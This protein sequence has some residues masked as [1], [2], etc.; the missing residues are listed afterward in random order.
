M[1]LLRIVAAVLI[2]AVLAHESRLAGSQRPGPRELKTRNILLVTTDGLRWQ[3]VFGGADAALLTRE[4]GG[5]VDVTAL[6]KAF[7]RDTP[8]RRREVLLPFFWS[9]IVQQG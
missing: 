9:T 7:D 6:K 5:V 2:A 4:H 8:E 1:K 3:E